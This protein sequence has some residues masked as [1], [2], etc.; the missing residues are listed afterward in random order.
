M[1]PLTT[2]KPA[3]QPTSR[4]RR[5]ARDRQFV[6]ALGGDGTALF[7]SWLFQRIAPPVLPFAL[8]SLGFL[9]NFDFMGCAAATGAA[10]DN[11]IRVNLRAR[12]RPRGGARGHP[13]ILGDRWLQCTPD[14]PQSEGDRRGDS[15]Q[16]TDS[17]STS[18]A[19]DEQDPPEQRTGSL[20]RPMMQFI[21]DV[22]R[23]FRGI[24]AQEP[25][26][27]YEPWTLA[28]AWR[29]I[30]AQQTPH[31]QP[32]AGPPATAMTLDESPPKEQDAARI[33]QSQP[34][35]AAEPRADD[36]DAAR[37]VAEASADAD[38]GSREEVRSVIEDADE[39]QD[40]RRRRSSESGGI[41]PTGRH[42]Y[43]IVRVAFR[44]GQPGREQRLMRKREDDSI[45]M[46]DS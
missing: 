28:R 27:R 21:R 17:E 13:W 20:I 18:E 10:L 7:T 46:A 11:G 41:N 37:A 32:S 31:R 33:E 24:A 42:I 6:V 16:T 12:R 34:L 23:R 43:T 15:P 38:A 35:D 26:L 40:S 9:T 22:W 25:M 8:G 5:I 36:S 14:E 4:A 39:H 3:R 29:P 44:V 2:F 45:D 19:G 30:P 1:L